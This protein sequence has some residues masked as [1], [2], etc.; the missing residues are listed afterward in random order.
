M[1]SRVHSWARINQAM[2][3][4]VGSPRRQPPAAAGTPHLRCARA[5]VRNAAATAAAAAAGFQLR[6]QLAL[7]FQVQRLAAAG[8]GLARRRWRRSPTCGWPALA[9]WLRGRLDLQ[10]KGQ[11]RRELVQAAQVA[12]M[13]LTLQR[14]AHACWHCPNRHTAGRTRRLLL[15]QATHRWRQAKLGVDGDLPGGEGGWRGPARR[16]VCTSGLRRGWRR[17][18][19]GTAARG[20]VGRMQRVEVGFAAQVDGRVHGLG[21]QGEERRRRRR[22]SAAAA[23][24]A[25]GCGL[26]QAHCGGSNDVWDQ[27]HYVWVASDAAQGPGQGRAAGCR[28]VAG[29]AGPATHC[30]STRITPEDLCSTSGGREGSGRGSAAASCCRSRCGVQV[31]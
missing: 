28:R 18:R 24:A 13:F 10:V 12:L 15:T 19:C 14:H 23:P 20:G 4:I 31:V 2:C 25:A 26:L 17:R 6:H 30:K 27:C 22:A 11:E 8:G 1:S 7:Q 9:G 3:R 29:L 5:A 16:P 21:G